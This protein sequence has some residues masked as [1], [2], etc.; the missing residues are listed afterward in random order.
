[1][2]LISGRRWNVTSSGCSGAGCER[3]KTR[4]NISTERGSY[5]EDPMRRVTLSGSPLGV[6]GNDSGGR[7]KF[8]RVF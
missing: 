8:W 4:S 5:C 6:G 1:M 7:D 3:G 2:C